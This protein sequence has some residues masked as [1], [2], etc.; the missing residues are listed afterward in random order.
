LRRLNEKEKAVEVL[1][2]ALALDVN[3]R[4]IRAQLAELLYEVGRV[5]EAEKHF[6]ILLRNRGGG[7]D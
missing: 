5:D 2:Q 1:K 3:S 4:S 7:K 6:S